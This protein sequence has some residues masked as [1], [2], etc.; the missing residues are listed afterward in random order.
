MPSLR[1]IFLALSL[2]TLGASDCTRAALKTF[3]D[4][5]IAAQTKGD[6]TV[7]SDVTSY[8]ENFKTLTPKTGIIATPLVIAHNRSSYDTTNCS[9]YTELIITDSKHPYVL[10]T[11][12]HYSA[13]VSKITK[14]ELLVTQQ[15]DWLFNATGTYYWASKESWDTIPEAKRDTRAVIQAAADAYL[16]IFKD[17]TV[18]V[19]WGTPCDRL[20][21]GS[22][23]GTGKA[24]DSCD[25]G[26]PNNLDLTS[27]RYVIDE[28]VGA[29]DVF[30]AFGGTSG[31][32]DSHEFRIESGKIRYVHTLTNMK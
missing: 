20:E 28:S 32:P 6:P 27:R 23:T 31:R 16:D 15:G 24:T 19:P 30:L 8:S 9:T 5:L 18:K 25:V 29:V 21:G 3:T 12:I 10:G 13:D 22:Y 4:N 11:Q 7:F 14:M 17:K 2:A 1:T 26:I